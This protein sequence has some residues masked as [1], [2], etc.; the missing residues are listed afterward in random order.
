M[1]FGPLICAFILAVSVGH[2]EENLFQP[3]VRSPRLGDVIYL[4]LPDRFEDGDPTNNTGHS[5]SSDPNE[6]GFDPSNPN[7]FH[8]GDLKG[9]TDK[10]DYVRD[11]GATSIWLTPI[12]RNRAV[13]RYGEKR[14]AGYHGY[15]I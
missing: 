15:W 13:Q 5:P 12:F 3:S 1:R 9:I 7:F 4:L 14:V 6:N 10:L 2:A 11:L 8:G